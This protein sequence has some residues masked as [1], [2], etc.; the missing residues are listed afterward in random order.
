MFCLLIH[1]RFVPTQTRDRFILGLATIQGGVKILINIE[2]IFLEDG[3][4][5]LPPLTKA[6]PTQPEKG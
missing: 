6:E 5:T 4:L 3:T 1:S 2:K